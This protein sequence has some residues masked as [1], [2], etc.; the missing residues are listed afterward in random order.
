MPAGMSLHCNNMHML[1]HV[2]P[3]QRQ[4]NHFLIFLFVVILGLWTDLLTSKDLVLYISLKKIW[5]VFTFGKM[6]NHPR[7]KKK[8]LGHEPKCLKQL[9]GSWP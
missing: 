3:A 9:S 4:I 8:F 1:L 6:S 5:L 7:R 2:V